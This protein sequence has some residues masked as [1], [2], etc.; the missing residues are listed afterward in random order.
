LNDTNPSYVAGP[1]NDLPPNAFA[2]AAL[3]HDGTRIAVVGGVS[4][5]C[6]SDT[7]AH[8][9]GITGNPGTGAWWDTNINSL[10]RRRGSALV[11]II[12]GGGEYMMLLG[13]IADTYSCGKSTTRLG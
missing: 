8:V 3:S 11:P 9:Y 5:N 4:S 10:V 2:G 12:E 7:I 6:S 1:S 13:G